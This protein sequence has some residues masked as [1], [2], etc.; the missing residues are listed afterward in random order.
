MSAMRPSLDRLLQH[1]R[2]QR[3]EY[4]TVL[5]FGAEGRCGRILCE[6]A[7]KQRLPRALDI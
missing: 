2:P 6:S 7:R 5:F 3:G 1:R 4:P